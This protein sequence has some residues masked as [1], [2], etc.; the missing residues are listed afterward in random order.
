MKLVPA[1]VSLTW[2]VML[3][4][5]ETRLPSERSATLWVR[6]AEAAMKFVPAGV[7]LTWP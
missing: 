4:P 7:P 5:Q 3:S 6:P 2:L 1:G